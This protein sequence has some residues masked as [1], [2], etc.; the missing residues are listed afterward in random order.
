MLFLIY[1]QY[2][3]HVLG[4]VP[5]TVSRG[6][7]NYSHRGLRRKGFEKESSFPSLTGTLQI[8]PGKEGV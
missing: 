7:S 3:L 8:L 2:R 4:K 1:E 6:T 5:N